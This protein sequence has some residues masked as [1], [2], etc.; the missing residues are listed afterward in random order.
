[1]KN[2]PP[3][4]SPLGSYQYSLVSDI[5][6]SQKIGNVQTKVPLI[7]LSSHR[8]VKPESLQVRISGNGGCLTTCKR[9]IIKFLT[10]LS[11]K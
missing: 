11:I 6:F 1:M 9:A 5:L 3:L 8:I 2:V 4:V 7:L 10:T